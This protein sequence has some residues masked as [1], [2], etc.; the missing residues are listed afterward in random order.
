M[1]CMDKTSCANSMFQKH[2]LLKDFALGESK[3]DGRREPAAS[4]QVL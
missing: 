4:Y 2:L 1:L 3:D